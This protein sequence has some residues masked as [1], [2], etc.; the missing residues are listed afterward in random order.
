[1]NRERERGETKSTI[2]NHKHSYLHLPLSLSCS[3]YHPKTVGDNGGKDYYPLAT[4]NNDVFR[5]DAAF[6][7]AHLRMVTPSSKEARWLDA[8][9]SN[10]LFVVVH[11]AETILLDQSLILLFD[12]LHRV[13]KCENTARVTT[14][15]LRFEE[16]TW[17]QAYLFLLFWHLFP[18]FWLGLEVLI[19]LSE[20]AL[21]QV[22]DLWLLLWCHFLR[23]KERSHLKYDQFAHHL[24]RLWGLKLREG[25]YLMSSP[26]SSL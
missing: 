21:V 4:V 11:D 24:N 16:T 12:F 15:L 22:S 20:V 10:S 17:M 26:S 7:H 14:M 8:E 2:T 13:Q 9:V 5:S 6:Q 25:N 18:C 19:H 23:E 3:S 1:M